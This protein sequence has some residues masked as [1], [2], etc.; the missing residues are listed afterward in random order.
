MIR[1]VVTYGAETWSTTLQDEE[2]LNVFEREVL[3]AIIGP[4]RLAENDY[5]SRFNHELYEIYKDID[6]TTFVRL[7]RL[8]WAGHILRRDNDSLLMNMYKGDF[9]KTAKNKKELKNLLEAVK[10]RAWE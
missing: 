4:I 5:R 8:E 7:R 10:S 9:S 6:I 2:S 1:P 3:R